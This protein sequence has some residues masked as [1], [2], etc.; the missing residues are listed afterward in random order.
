MKNKMPLM[1]KAQVFFHGIL[2]NV[3]SEA[4]KDTARLRRTYKSH[5]AARL[6]IIT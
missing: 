1:P 6:P 2:L 4:L 5:H 3:L